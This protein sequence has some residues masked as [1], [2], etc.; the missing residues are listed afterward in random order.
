MK[1]A[2]KRMLGL[3]GMPSCRNGCLSN[4]L[5]KVLSADMPRASHREWRRSPISVNISFSVIKSISMAISN[6]I[7][8][9]LL[10]LVPGPKNRSQAR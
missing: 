5:L 1:R 2:A 8:I 10:A 9:E 7:E 3:N 4:S 6:S